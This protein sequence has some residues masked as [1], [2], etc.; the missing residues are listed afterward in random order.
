MQRERERE[1]EREGT[2]HWDILLSFFV[3]LF[4]YNS[5]AFNTFT[6]LCNHQH[7]LVPEHFHHP[8]R[9]PTPISSHSLFP[10]A[11]GNQ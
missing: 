3:F 4:F 9:K 6:A 2:I 11:P 5:V 7:S 8:K 10:P 1:R